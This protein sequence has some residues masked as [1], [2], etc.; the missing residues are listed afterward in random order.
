VDAGDGEMQRHLL[1]GLERQVG[2]VERV[3]V[4]P[5]PVLLVAA[6]G[7]P[8]RHDGNALVA[9]ESLVTLEGLAPGRV[10]GWISR[11]LVRDRIERERLR[12]LEEY[13]DEVGDAFEPIE[14]GWGLH[15]PEPTAASRS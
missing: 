2:Q 3:A 8:L 10:L 5:V 15:R 6:A 7:K 12:C 9:Q 1:V 4:D 13:Q 11:H 14:L